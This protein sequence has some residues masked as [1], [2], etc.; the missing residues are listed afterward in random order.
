MP[1]LDQQVKLVDGRN[2]GYD[3]FGQPDGA[4]LFYIHGTPKLRAWS[5]APSG[6]EELAQRLHVRIIV[7]DRPG[8]GLSSYLPKRGIADWRADVTALAD[9]LGLERFAV[10][11]YSGGGPYALVCALAIPHRLTHVGV[12]SGAGD[13]SLPS[14]VDG[15]PAANLKYFA[16]THEKPMLSRL[17][18]GMTGLLAKF[19]R[20]QGDRECTGFPACLGPPG[21]VSSRD[22]GWFS[23]HAA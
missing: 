12:V 21:F 15:I 6:G 4:P 9:H 1:W 7:P 13:F 5:G 8:M 14:L 19:V 17:I 18:L 2:L 11:G 16:M 22:A 20:R 3:E 23:E 10:L